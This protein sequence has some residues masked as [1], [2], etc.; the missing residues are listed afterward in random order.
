MG[1]RNWAI[2]GTCLSPLSEIKIILDFQPNIP[3]FHHSVWVKLQP[4]GVNSKPGHLGPDSFNA[5]ERLRENSVG[6]KDL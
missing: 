4:T 6:C 3:L 1:W 2:L 5:L